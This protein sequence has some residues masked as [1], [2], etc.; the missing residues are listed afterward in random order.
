MNIDALTIFYQLILATFLGA[1][2]GFERE[3]HGKAAGLRT[4]SLVALG[5]CLFTIVSA[6]GFLGVSG[7]YDPSR[8]A[9][10]IVVGIGFIGVGIIFL[11]GDDVQGL[12]TAAGIW[13]S[14]AVGMAVGVQMYWVALFASFLSLFILWGLKF[15]E[16][17][18]H[19]GEKDKNDS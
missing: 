15:A 4:Y 8:V 18:F 16:R 13:L 12:T 10:Q 7:A 9:S 14:A 1:L 11:R 6:A 19:K 2:V 3:V 5:S 17:P